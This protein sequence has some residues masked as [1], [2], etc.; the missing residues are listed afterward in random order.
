MS[1]TILITGSTDGIGMETARDL[2]SK[3]HHVILHGRSKDKL[4]K[5]FKELSRVGSVDFFQADLSGLSAVEHFAKEVLSKFKSI[6]VLINNAGVLKTPNPVSSM[7]IDIRF[8]VNTI[9]PYLLTNKL[10]PALSKESRV[11]NLSSAAQETVNLDALLGKKTLGDYEAYAQS[12]LAI[13]M[14]SIYL[15]K[16]LGKNGPAII[17]VNP[18]SLLG[19]KM[20]KEAFGTEGKDI[21]IG[22][23]ILASLSLEDKFK[24]DSGM[25]FDNDLGAFSNPHADALSDKKVLNV[26]ETI[27]SI[28]S[29][30][31]L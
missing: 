1:K 10:L 19:S 6:D 24:N 17:A 27:E 7:G 31:L 20:V 3:G 4:Q 2:V 25:Y 11:I 16:S 12:K 22:V 8:V 26:I 5:V 9:A 28:L 13:T 14:W 29:R 21:G 18:G 23:R 15:A 30:S